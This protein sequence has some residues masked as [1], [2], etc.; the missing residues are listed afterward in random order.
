[1]D[2][3][4][5]H[6]I[7]GTG[8]WNA[9]CS[10]LLEFGKNARITAV[11]IRLSPPGIGTFYRSGSLIDCFDLPSLLFEINNVLGFIFQIRKLFQVFSN[12]EPNINKRKNISLERD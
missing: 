6:S 1:M 10:G 11:T 4:H 9:Y 5:H 7:V 3:K 8:Y 12:I 2:V